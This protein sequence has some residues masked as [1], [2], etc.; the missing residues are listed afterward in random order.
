MNTIVIID[1][2]LLSTNLP[3]REG[4]SVLMYFNMNL[5]IVCESPNIND[6]KTKCSNEQSLTTE[7]FV[8]S[9]FKSIFRKKV[10]F[11][12]IP[13][14]YMVH[15][16]ILIHPIPNKKISYVVLPFIKNS[17][18][19]IYPLEGNIRPDCKPAEIMVIYRPLR[20]ITLNFELQI[21]IPELCKTQVITFYA[22]TKPRLQRN[23]HED[24]YRHKKYIETKINKLTKRKPILLKKTFPTLKYKLR[25]DTCKEHPQYKKKSLEWS[26]KFHM[27]QAVN[28]IYDKYYENFHDEHELRGPL[29]IYLSE[30]IEHKLKLQD[31]FLYKSEIY[32]KE[33]NR[34]IFH[35]KPKVGFDAKFLSMK[36]LQII[37][38]ER[39]FN[40]VYYKCSIIT[41]QFKELINRDKSIKIK[42][43]ILRTALKYP[44]TTITLDTNKKWSLYYC[45]IN[46]F[47]EAARK[48]ILQNRLIK[49]LK[50]L[51]NLTLPQAERLE[52]ND[53]SNKK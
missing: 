38:M 8:N 9:T 28:Q 16:I 25:T 29:N 4:T 31:L 14:G 51:K 2:K 5:N 1:K 37:T 13:L 11:G 6:I 12:N 3:L 44:E 52:M 20:Y 21:Y 19:D 27:M 46:T 48:I 53:Q 36:E 10:N 42:Q 33:N 24:I 39:K 45:K 30:M 47:I 32:R 26:Y 17:C 22:D 18:I 40:W 23:L 41:T 50:K 35:H 7:I 15:H 49:I 34:T 43:R